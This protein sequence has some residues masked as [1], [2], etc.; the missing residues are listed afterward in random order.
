MFD[1][2]F[3]TIRKDV[4]RSVLADG[5]FPIN[6]KVKWRKF[7]DAVDYD[8][9]LAV[10]EFPF[11]DIELEMWSSDGDWFD[12]KPDA[13]NV[14]L[15]YVVC[16]QGRYCPNGR[17]GEYDWMTDGIPKHEPNV[18]FS[19]SDWDK[20]LEQDMLNALD[21]YVKERNLSYTEPND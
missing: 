5:H 3:R 8:R 11:V 13:D 6:D 12:V 2:N 18:D 21:K 20:Q 16:T 10:L 19:A 7:C 1:R 9:V 15:G 17:W 4:V 14:Y